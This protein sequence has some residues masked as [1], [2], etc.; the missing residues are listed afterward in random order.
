[1][2]GWGNTALTCVIR[3]TQSFVGNVFRAPVDVPLY[4]PTSRVRE[5][6][7]GET[8]ISRGGEDSYVSSTN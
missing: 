3:K 2:L 6:R 8:P 5:E 7:K 4:L 1:M